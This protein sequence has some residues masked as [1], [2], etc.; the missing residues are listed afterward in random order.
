MSRLRRPILHS[1][2]FFVTTN[3]SKGL[4]PFNE[5]EFGLLAEAL[6]RTRENAPVAVCAYCF[7]PDHVHAILFPHKDT[8]ISDVMMRFKVAAS[9]RI[10]PIRG[11]AFWQA[12][13]HDR[14]LRTRAAYD[15]A[16]KYIHVNPVE[17]RLV[18]DPLQWKWSSARW[19]AEQA[20]PIAMD[21]VGLP[22][23]AGDRI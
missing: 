10:Q 15:E 20:G 19:L 4:R 12:R 23:N 11:R 9:R 3:L 7:M 8:T 5:T 2:F 17:R 6:V 1:R 22:L 14:V 18:D 16:I 13:F 21:D